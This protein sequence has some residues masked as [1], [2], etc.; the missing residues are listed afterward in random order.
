MIFSVSHVEGV[1]VW[2]LLSGI[3][4]DYWV[5]SCHFWNCVGY[6]IFNGN[7]IVNKEL[8]RMWKEAALACSEVINYPNVCFNESSE[9]TK[10]ANQDK[11]DNL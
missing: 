1:H 6:V 7:M 11:W 9:T 5:I 10:N 2:F 8:E 4:I 3:L